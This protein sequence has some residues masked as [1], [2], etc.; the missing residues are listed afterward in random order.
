MRLDCSSAGARIAGSRR[1]QGGIARMHWVHTLTGT[2]D[3]A[4][5][6]PLIAIFSVWLLLTRQLSALCWWSVSVT[7]CG[8]ATAILK[9][10]FYVC[11]LSANF[12]NPSGH[13]S[14]S[15]LVYGALTLLTASSLLG[16]RRYV[17]ALLGATF[18]FSIGMS[19]LLLEAH[20]LPEVFVGWAIGTF[21]LWI[22]ARA[23]A[24]RE[25]LYLRPLIV[26]CAV[27]TVLLTGQEVRAEDLLHALG[28]NLRDMGLNCINLRPV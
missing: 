1:A 22:F 8:A 14:L 5:L 18:V 24:P 3:L 9:I 15:T 21:A 6:V 17:V 2:G 28:L 4:V 16:W 23:F 20:S 13:T 27:V 11:P 19:R 26:A 7:T 12:H 25:Y 10:Y